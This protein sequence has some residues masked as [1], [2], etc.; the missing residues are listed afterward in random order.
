MGVT[1]SLSSTALRVPPGGEALLEVTIRNGGSVV[2]QFAF[3]VLGE[4]AAWSTVE[5]PS[6]SLFPGDDGR[7]FVRFAPPRRAGLPAGPVPFA[8]KVTS[9]EDPDGSVVEEGTVEVEPFADSLAELVPRTARGRRSAVYDLAVDNR[10]NHPLNATLEPVE[11]DG[12]L[13]FRFDPPALLVE[14]GTASFSRVRVAARRRFLRGPAQTRVFQVRVDAG[15]PAPMVADG[16]FLQ[17]AVVPAWVPRAI[18][19]AL[20]GALALLI[21][22]LT[23]LRPAVR[24]QAEDAVRDEVAAANQQAAAAN[25]AA[26]AASETASAALEA[27]TEAGVPV[28]TVPAEPAAS[29]LTTSTGGRIEVEAAPGSTARRNLEGIPADKVFQLTD[30]VL[31][32]PSADVGLVRIRRGG[33]VLLE[34]AMVNFRDLDYHFISPLTVPPGEPVTFEVE[35]AA[36]A[37]RPCRPS[38]Y[39]GGFLE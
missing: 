36:D 25:E 4:A 27:L 13:S 38:V 24:S 20:L 19:A 3:Q 2:D 7:A 6:V 22:W 29:P 31:Q 28:S 9:R 21:L 26:R 35:C 37:P 11:P 12:L 32:N 16:A 33:A 39:L 10:G 34:V 18:V 8:V 5:P 14:P 15:G 1:A 23:V 30:V 17:E